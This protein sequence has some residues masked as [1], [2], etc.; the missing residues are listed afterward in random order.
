MRRSIYPA[1][2]GIFIIAGTMPWFT[3]G[4]ASTLTVGGW[5]AGLP[6]VTAV[7]A[8][9]S[10]GLLLTISDRGAGWRGG[11]VG[12][13]LAALLLGLVSLTGTILWLGSNSHTRATVAEQSVPLYHASGPYVAL[14]AGTAAVIA[15]A[16]ALAASS[17]QVPDTVTKALKSATRRFDN[18]H[19][20]TTPQRNTNDRTRPKTA[21][22][23]GQMVPE[24]GKKDPRM[25]EGRAGS[26]ADV[27][28]P[29]SSGM[30]TPGPGTGEEM[31]PGG[32]R[33][34]RHGDERPRSGPGPAAQS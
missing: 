23:P 13:R 1:L 32:Q 11:G 12:P 33:V 20:S 16:H 8:G 24:A 6:A 17:E 31:G 9:G 34:R 10:A 27:H 22:G 19:S 14:L 7:V 2:A 18:H 4:P 3:L 29:E 21:A 15:A 28:M 25:E 26:P 30:R 5:H